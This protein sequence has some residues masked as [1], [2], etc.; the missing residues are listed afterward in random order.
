MV[1]GL[2]QTELENLG[3]K[4]AFKKVV[5]LQAKNEI[6]LHLIIGEDSSSNKATE[7]GISFKQAFRIF[8]L[9]S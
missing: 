6:E 8:F 4:A 9:Q 7:K 3:L 2:G 1:D 5:N